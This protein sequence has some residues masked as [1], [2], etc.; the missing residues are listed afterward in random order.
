MSYVRKMKRI[1]NDARNCILYFLKMLN[2]IFRKAIK[3]F[4]TKIYTG[5]MK[6]FASLIA[7]VLEI[8]ERMWR[9]S[10]NWMK[11]D[12]TTEGIYLSV[13]I[14]VWKITSWFFCTISRRNSIRA[15]INNIN[16]KI[17]VI[18]IKQEICRVMWINR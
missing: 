3:E 6:A 4:I 13:D 10:P 7:A 14:S 15:K 5:M 17:Y 16:R 9:I 1:C 8:K 12:L 2:S 11:Q 18:W